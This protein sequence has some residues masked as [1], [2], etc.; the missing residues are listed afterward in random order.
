[1]KDKLE[2]IKMENLNLQFQFQNMDKELQ[3]K[4]KRQV[5]IVNQLEDKIRK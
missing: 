4:G 2:N 3:E 1:M 5:D